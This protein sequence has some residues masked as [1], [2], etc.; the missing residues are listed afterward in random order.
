MRDSGENDKEQWR[1]RWKDLQS[2]LVYFDVV[3]VFNLM[4]DYQRILIIKN[5][6]HLSFITQ[7]YKI[8]LATTRPA[9]ISHYC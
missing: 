2:F 6:L 9:T 8:F 3:F 5:V 4:C 1:D 7:K